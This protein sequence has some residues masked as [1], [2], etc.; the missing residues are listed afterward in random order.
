MA[1][2]VSSSSRE[3]NF[4]KPSSV[5]FVSVLMLLAV[6]AGGYWVWKYG[7]VYYNRFKVDEILREGAVEAT[8]L[9][10]M[11]DAAQQQLQAKIV[12]TVIERVGGRGITVEDN[13]LQVYFSDD[14][15]TLHADYYVIVKHLNGKTKTVT[16]RRSESVPE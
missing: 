4:K 15:R 6:L 8:G 13:G 3:Y 11:T 14:I 7:P 9:R 12:G 1:G 16:V 5:N 2:P 10:R